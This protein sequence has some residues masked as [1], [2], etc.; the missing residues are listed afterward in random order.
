MH[1]VRTLTFFAAHYR[2][3]FM[4]EHV[5]GAD[6][7]LAD[8][9]SRNKENLFLL[10]VPEASRHPTVTPLPLV[11]LVAQDMPWTSTAWIKLF[12]DITQLP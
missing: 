1:L 9:I 3:W 11:D 6:N 10:Q 12:S 5:W 7:G 4:A 8:L 2:F